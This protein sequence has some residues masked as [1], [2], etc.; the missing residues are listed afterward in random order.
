MP[1]P[2]TRLTAFDFDIESFEQFPEKLREN[3]GY[4]VTPNDVWS[5]SISPSRSA[6]NKL[7]VTITVIYWDKERV[8]ER[9]KLE[10]SQNTQEYELYK[11][12]LYH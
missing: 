3:I 2:E 6:L 7:H 10:I 4:K 8:E 5:M 9:N 12:N 11:K 1:R